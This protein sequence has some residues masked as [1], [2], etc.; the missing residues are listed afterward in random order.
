[1]FQRSI[2]ISHPKVALPNSE[3]NICHSNIVSMDFMESYH[4][5]IDGFLKITFSI[6]AISHLDEA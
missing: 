4:I 1:M 6:Q 5:V 2:E 3:V